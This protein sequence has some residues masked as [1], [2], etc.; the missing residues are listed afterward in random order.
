[1][2]EYR[3][4]VAYIYEYTN[5]KKNKNTGFAKVESRNGTCRI[6]VHLQK[7]PQEDEALNIYGFVR[8]SG[9]LLGIFLGK[10]YRRGSA[11][12][13]RIQTQAQK[14]G[15]SVYAL[16]QLAGL[17]VESGGGRKY[18]TVFDEESVD[19]ARLVTELPQKVHTEKTEERR[20][21]SREEEQEKI[22]EERQEEKRKEERAEIPEERRE[23]KPEERREEEREEER[24]EIPEERRAEI[25]EEKQEESRKGE[26]KE[27][28][29]R[30]REIVTDKVQEESQEKV[31]KENQME[32]AEK[33]PEKAEGENCEESPEEKTMEA[34][35]RDTEEIS[36][37][38]H[39][40]AS[41]EK[42]AEAAVSHPEK[43]SEEVQE[44]NT[45]EC[46]TEMQETTEK[47]T[48][49][50]G[51]EMQEAPESGETLGMLHT[52]E[53]TACPVMRQNCP[54][55]AP[56]AVNLD[57]KW[58]YMS[59]R[60]PHFRPF[61]DD[62][63]ADCIQITPRELNFILQGNWRTGNNSFLMHGFCNYRHLLF[64][65]R[66]DGGYL[67]GIPG[68]HENQELF[69]ANMFGFPVFKEAVSRHP[70]GRFGYWCR[71]L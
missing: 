57:Q 6:Q 60:Y 22:P 24:A 28:Q 20:G 34:V 9:W 14:I 44:K 13:A 63:V 36:G 7:V 41:E 64:G 42:Q 12:E 53:A 26:T 33:K 55:F 39:G 65:K 46:G 16:E 45:E 68:I 67:L 4:F 21:E 66:K 17:W 3:R 69:M 62:E 59:R 47:N 71:I 10:M 15:G 52:Q 31:Q 25:S 5:G 58:Q 49:E 40:K 54:R 50:Y 37:G 30:V 51:T 11:C 32:A 70:R 38:I 23:E 18:L 29:E 1:M 2:S 48:E 61:A 8:E 27:D 35:K 43:L 56:C 19:T